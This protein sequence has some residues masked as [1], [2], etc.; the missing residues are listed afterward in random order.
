[1]W[2]SLLKL[3]WAGVY[4][5]MEG[6]EALA[7]SKGPRTIRA[8]LSALHDRQGAVR[9]AAAGSLGKIGDKSALPALVRALKDRDSGVRRYAATSLGRI[10]DSSAVPALHEL[11]QDEESRVRRETVD[12]L[13]KIGDPRS[14]PLLIQMLSDSHDVI[15]CSAAQAL[16]K[17]GDKSA[18][19]ALVAAMK[20]SLAEGREAAAAALDELG[21]TPTMAEDRSWHAVATGA[22]EDAVKEGEAAVPALE[23]ALHE[24]ETRVDAE[25]ALQAIAAKC[26]LDAVRDM[27]ESAQNK[28]KQASGSRNC[29]H[30]ANG[31]QWWSKTLLLMESGHSGLWP[32]GLRP[33]HFS[34]ACTNCRDGFCREHAEGDRCPFCGKT[35]SK[36]PSETLKE[37]ADR[38]LGELLSGH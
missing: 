27:I 33:D 20:D 18:V 4:G 16:S 2:W 35:L 31:L 38:R 3:K 11:L 21:W 19:G 36:H 22:Y 34:G 17:F 30:C 7:K 25:K 24:K 23:K 29:A 37:I 15:R 28:R 1:M 5:R 12:A 14:L 6:A 8:L 32:A 26:N 9:A 13:C 10:G